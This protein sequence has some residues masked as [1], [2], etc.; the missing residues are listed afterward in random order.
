MC[1]KN[2]MI[3][4][5]YKCVAIFLTG[6]GIFLSLGL[7]DAFHPVMFQ[8]FTIQSNLLCFFFLVFSAFHCVKEMKLEREE[9]CTDF[10]PHFKGAVIMAITLTML[11][12]QFLLSPS[13]FALLNTDGNITSNLLHFIV[14]MLIIFDYL[15]FDEKGNFSDKDPWCW[16]I[17]PY[18]YYF[19]VIIAPYFHITYQDGSRYPYYFIDIDL[20]GY[21]PVIGFIVFLTAI[22]LIGGYF[23]VGLDHFLKKWYK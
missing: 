21:M 3:S 23:L 5:L 12:Y 14:P 17:V 22:Y 10:M 1:V 20:L 4:L 6:L 13:P 19:F 18:L 7:P 9:G 11:I 2:R 15:L 16:L 8:Y